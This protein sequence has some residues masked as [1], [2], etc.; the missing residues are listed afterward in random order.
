MIRDYE[1]QPLGYIKEKFVRRREK[2]LKEDLEEMFIERNMSI[3]EISVYLNYNAR[4][5]QDVL[6]EYGL[7]KDRK[8]VY[9]KQ[10]ETLL[11][12]KG[13]ENPFQLTS[14]KENARKTC[15]EKY[16]KEYFVQTEEYREKNSKTRLL[17]YGEDPYRREKYKET[18]KKRFGVENVAYK[19]F[20]EEQMK[21]EN[22]R[23][24]TKRFIEEND[25]QSALEFSEKSGIKQYASLTLLHRHGLM[26][27]FKRR[28]S[29]EERELQE[30]LNELGIEYTEHYRMDNNQEIDILIPSMNIGIE[31]NGDIWHCEVF[32][33]K[34]YH[35]NK[36]KYALEHHGIFIYHIFGYEWKN[37]KDIIKNDL[38]NLLGKSL[39]E[40]DSGKCYVEEVSKKEKKDFLESFDIRGNDHSSLSYGLF[41][42]GLLVFLMTFSKTLSNTSEWSVS[43]MCSRTDYRI[44]GGEKRL[45]EQFIET[46]LPER[47]TGNSDL[48][49]TLGRV[50]ETLGLKFLRNSLPKPVWIKSGKTKTCRNEVETMHKLGYYRVYNCGD[51]IWEWKNLHK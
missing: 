50:Y 33:D 1:K 31:Y 40:I 35:Y 25:I 14:S 6:K 32:R 29:Q 48:S 13:V 46:V 37:G 30:F 51:R 34:D 39:I 9:E 7:K 8:K 22:D 2:P 24:Y 11:R 5:L 16:G 18:C 28:V 45:F 42:D 47:V 21:F 19:H 20:T 10:R 23:E 38:K 43:R 41:Y 26:E 36:S 4:M 12:E 49:K 44:I 3:R 27:L 17:K 15:L